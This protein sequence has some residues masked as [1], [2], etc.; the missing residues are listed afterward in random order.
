M[1]N[2]IK[3]LGLKSLYGL[4]CVLSGPTFDG[5]VTRMSRQTGKEGKINPTQLILMTF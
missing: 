4:G 1:L 2:F 3:A 5:F